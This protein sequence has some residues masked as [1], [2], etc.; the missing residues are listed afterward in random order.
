MDLS[1]LK[2]IWSL[3]EMRTTHKFVR[4]AEGRLERLCWRRERLWSL[5]LPP[6]GINSNGSWLTEVTVEK[7]PPPASI[8]SGH[9]DGLV[10]GIRPVDILM[11]PV[12]CQSFRRVELAVYQNHLL[13]CVTRFVYVGTAKTGLVTGLTHGTERAVRMCRGVGPQTALL[14]PHGKKMHMWQHD[15]PRNPYGCTLQPSA[16]SYNLFLFPCIWMAGISRTGNC[17]FI[18]LPAPAL[19]AQFSKTFD[20]SHVN[21]DSIDSQDLWTLEI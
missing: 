9:W 13:S 10:S 11:N 12:Y 18:F 17:H 19:T 6:C 1:I 20:F 14:Q 3:D 5:R 16:F 8:C 4:E 15:W 2:G 7:C 21:F